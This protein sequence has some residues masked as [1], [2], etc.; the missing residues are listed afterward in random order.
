MLRLLWPS[1]GIFLP[2][3]VWV[4]PG[5]PLGYLALIVFSLLADIYRV[6]VLGESCQ[7][8]IERNTTADYKIEFVNQLVIAGLPEEFLYRGYFLSRLIMGFGTLIGVALSSIYFGVSHIRSMVKGEMA[9]D[10]YKALTTFAGAIIY[11][12][13]FIN[14]GLIPCIIVHLSINMSYGWISRLLLPRFVRMQTQTEEQ[15]IHSHTRKKI[16]SAEKKG[17]CGRYLSVLALILT[18]LVKAAS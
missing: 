12:T 14:S 2:G 13:I 18:F 3:S 4:F 1:M 16:Q 5:I 17:F 10:K 15:S 8:L 11:A 7:E 9:G 6:K